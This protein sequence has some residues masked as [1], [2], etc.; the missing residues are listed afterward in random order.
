MIR[1][2][3]P[4]GTLASL[5]GAG[6]K[7]KQGGPPF[8]QQRQ[9]GQRQCSYRRSRSLFRRPNRYIGGRGQRSNKDHPHVAW[10]GGA[11]HLSK[12]DGGG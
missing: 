5:W 7:T 1:V 2:V 12:G 4:E 8:K 3:I 6:L 9:F 11:T 10:A